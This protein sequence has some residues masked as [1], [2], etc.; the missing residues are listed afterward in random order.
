MY[1]V[2]IPLVFDPAPLRHKPTV[3]TAPHNDD[4]RIPFTLPTLPFPLYTFEPRDPR[5]A[6]AAAILLSTPHP[7]FQ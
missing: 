2:L 5:H 4:K 3:N 1:M 7:R 6:S